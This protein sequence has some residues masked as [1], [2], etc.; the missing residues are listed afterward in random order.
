MNL[1]IISHVMNHTISL[2]YFCY[3]SWYSSFKCSPGAP[4]WTSSHWDHFVHVICQTSLVFAAWH[5]VVVV[6]FV[7]GFGYDSVSDCV[8]FFCESAGKVIT[9]RRACRLP[10]RWPLNFRWADGAVSGVGVQWDGA[11]DRWGWV[12]SNTAGRVCRRWVR[13]GRVTGWAWAR[14]RRQGSIGHGRH[15]SGL[16][17]ENSG[18]ERDRWR[19]ETQRGDAG[20][21]TGLGGSWQGWDGCGT[22]QCGAMV[23]WS[24]HDWSRSLD[25]GCCHPACWVL[26]TLRQM[27]HNPE[28]HLWCQTICGVQELGHLVG[29]LRVTSCIF[30]TEVVAVRLCLAL[31]PGQVLQVM[32]C[33][34]KYISFLHLRISGF[35]KRQNR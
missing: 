16:D 31:L 13:R 5:Y 28:L 27:R 15:L 32:D 33:H 11:T 8:R 30:V 18:R 7:M 12:R 22:G 6:V 17:E 26:D 34:L 2:W 29:T 14:H 1:R 25:I 19:D 35:L 9:Y 10:G 4:H 21:V 3:S 24:R 23:S 20:W